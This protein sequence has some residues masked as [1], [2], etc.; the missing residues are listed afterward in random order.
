MSSIF[1]CKLLKVFSWGFSWAYWIG[2]PMHKSSFC[3]ERC[4]ALTRHPVHQIH[5]ICRPTD[6]LTE[7]GEG[8][9]ATLHPLGKFLMQSVT[10][11]IRWNREGPSWKRGRNEVVPLDLEHSLTVN[12]A[13]WWEIWATLRDCVGFPPPSDDVSND[14]FLFQKLACDNRSCNFFLQGNLSNILDTQNEIQSG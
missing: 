2:P 9:M 4:L 8:G 1:Y 14:T 11:F 7:R 12:R 5:F 10:H 3:T 13:L 6:R